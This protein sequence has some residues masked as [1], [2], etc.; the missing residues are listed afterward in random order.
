MFSKHVNYWL[1]EDGFEERIIAFV[2]AEFRLKTQTLIVV[3]DLK[4]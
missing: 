2:N 3:K 1:S 4:G